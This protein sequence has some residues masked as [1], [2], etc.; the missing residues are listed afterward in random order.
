MP[1]IISRK[2]QFCYTHIY[3]T[4][5]ATIKSL[6]NDEVDD[7]QSL[8]KCNTKLHDIIKDNPELN[9]YYKFAYVR[10]PYDWIVS[11]FSHIST[12]EEHPDYN[13][14]KRLNFYDFIEWL[15][16]VGTKRR[17]DDNLPVYRKQSDFLFHKN[18]I[19]VDEVYTFEKLCDDTGLSNANSLMVKLGFDMPKQ[20]P[21]LNK[22][23]MYVNW[24]SI[25]NAK[26]YKIVNE[27]FSDDFKNFKYKKNVY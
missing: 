27:L 7:L 9:E 2:N 4:G 15:N 13:T 22:S 20:I 24:Y 25:F 21:V 3:N 11:I 17:E 5:G 18:Q 26:S 14:V 23:E 6:L 1:I 16:D 10:H 8:G 19:L 12:I